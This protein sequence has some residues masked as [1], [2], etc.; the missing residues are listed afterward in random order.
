[1]SFFDTILLNTIC[2]MFPLLVYL[3]YLAYLN[4]SNE[5]LKF[6]ST[7]FEIALVTSLFFTIKLTGNRYNNYTII[8]L[9]IPILFSYLR[10]KTT[11][12]LI[13]SFIV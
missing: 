7:L 10:G 13:L 8:L 1:M 5:N 4:N 6:E 12:A 3:I 9:N 2:I 11:F